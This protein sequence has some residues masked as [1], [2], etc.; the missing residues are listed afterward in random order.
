MPQNTSK[1]KKLRLNFEL[2]ADSLIEKYQSISIKF[3][4]QICGFFNNILLKQ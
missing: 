4:I 3:K 2:T 1:A